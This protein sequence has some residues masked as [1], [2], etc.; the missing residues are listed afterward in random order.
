MGQKGTFGP[1]SCESASA[2]AVLPVPGGPAKRS[3]RPAIF[4]ILIRSTTTP[5]AYWTIR[6][7]TKK[8]YLACQLLANHAL[9]HLLRV[10]V[11]LQPE[12]LDVR[13]GRDSLRL[14]GGFDFFDL[15]CSI[16]SVFKFL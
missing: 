1:S 15:H 5:A 16:S 12:A 10:S 3:A 7:I 13:M 9:V 4:F 8:A 11:G 2:M 6:N 14:R